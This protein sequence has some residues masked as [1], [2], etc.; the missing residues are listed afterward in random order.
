MTRLVLTR[1]AA[2][3]P[4]LFAVI[5]LAFFL[6]RLAPGGPFD[7][8]RALDPAIRANLEHL[9]GLDLPL[10]RQFGL[11]L[12]NL[13]HGDLGP[14]LHWRDFTVNEL[15]AIALPI[16]LQLGA[17]AL[18]LALAV[19]LP[20]GFAAGSREGG[21]AGGFGLTLLA[22]LGLAV[23][24]FVVAPL[25]QVWLG[26]DLRLLPVGGWEDGDWRH[27]LLPV[28]TLALPQ[29]AII[30]KLTGA[31]VREALAAPH[32][33]RPRA[34]RRPA[35]GAVLSRP[36]GGG[37]AHGVDRGR[38]DLRHSR[39]RSLL[40]R[41]RPVPRLSPDDGHRDRGRRHDRDLQPPRRHSLRP[42][43]SKGS[44]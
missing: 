30:A 27:Q 8:E 4:T 42:R 37:A 44:A 7:A 43:R 18:A 1:L 17:E 10:P 32:G 23:P 38:D 14:S 16:S 11:Y 25:L 31:A 41:Q 39:H 34:A 22:L 6:M 24:S 3:V 36:G 33:G 5:A 26:L 2:G 28:V 12:W 13:A 35:A 20:L 21:G 29:V 9:Y 19:G 40:R 15:F